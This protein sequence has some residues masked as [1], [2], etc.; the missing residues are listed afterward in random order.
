MAMIVD[1]IR[2][3][4]WMYASAHSQSALPKPKPVPRPGAR[5]GRRRRAID[6]ATAMRLDPRLRGLTAAQAQARLD[7]I[8]GRNRA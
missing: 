3:L 8:T 4:I 5:R 2:V 7:E 1:D 6:M